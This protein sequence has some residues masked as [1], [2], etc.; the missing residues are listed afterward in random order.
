M[1]DGDGDD[2]DD[3][4]EEEPDFNPKVWFCLCCLMT[5]DLRKDVRCH[6]WPCI[7]FKTLANS[8]IRHQATH[9]MGCQPGVC[10]WSLQYSSGV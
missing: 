4:E 6:V 1:T 5:P 3:E 8:Q 2:D 10:I 9:K 7:F